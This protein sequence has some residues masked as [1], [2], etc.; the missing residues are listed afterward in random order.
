MSSSTNANLKQTELKPYILHNT[1]PQEIHLSS[2]T[3]SSSMMSEGEPEVPQVQLLGYLQ[4][5]NHLYPNIYGGYGGYGG[6]GYPYS[7]YLYGYPYG[8]GYLAPSCYMRGCRRN[9]PWNL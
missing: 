5:Y 9:Y 8:L 2:C 3:K 4:R 1:I 6:Y 7:S